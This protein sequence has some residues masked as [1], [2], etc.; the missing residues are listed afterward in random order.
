[1]R[2]HLK[3]IRMLY[4]PSL[5]TELLLILEMIFAV[6]L[7]AMSTDSL[8]YQ[9]LQLKTADSCWKDGN[10]L[11]YTVSPSAQELLDPQAVLERY[12][13]VEA[14]DVGAVEMRGIPSEEEKL[15]DYSHLGQ[16]ILVR[17]NSSM[18]DKMAERLEIH[19][20]IDPGE[21]VAVCV[22]PDVAKLYP[23]GSEIILLDENW[24][25]KPHTVCGII[26]EAELPVTATSGSFKTVESL[27]VN[28]REL[29]RTNN[30]VFVSINE[31][32][33]PF[34]AGVFRLSENAD[35][36]KMAE[37][38]SGEYV[39]C[40]EF[41]PYTS[42]RNFSEESMISRDPTFL[43]QAVLL[44]LVFVSHFIGYLFLSTRNKE[45][46][47]ALLSI[48]GASPAKISTYNIRAVLL[49]VLPS[50]LLGTLIVPLT[51]KWAD[52]PAYGG[53]VVMWECIGA[54]TVF[55]TLMT[56]TAAR[57]RVKKGNT[58]LLYRKGT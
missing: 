45:R 13:E 15:R 50:M 56:V 57:G 46:T 10:Y 28:C 22:P 6:Q 37:E 11:Y 38:L 3:I 54:L 27:T 32:H 43:L 24:E 49:L 4:S 48:N 30:I 21:T 16:V 17:C 53:H 41:C 25:E 35:A 12:S 33:V 18:L 31:K 14:Y 52:T 23:L 47:N 42:M 20:E 55:Q 9:R 2:N 44:L 51:E 39:N 19:S 8:S 7:I 58:I 36:E 1:M 5:I 29:E 40:G 26:K 34:T